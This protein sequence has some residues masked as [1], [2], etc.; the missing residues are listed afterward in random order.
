MNSK[1]PFLAIALGAVAVTAGCT[2]PSKGTVYD[3]YRVGRT[4]HLDTGDVVAVRDVT[5]SG[6][7]GPIG[8]S[9]GGLVGHAAGRQAAGIG[10]SGA[11]LAGA[12]GAVVGAIAG[13]AVEEVVTRRTA[14]EVTIKLKSGDTIAIVQEPKEG[15]FVVGEH[16]QVLQG[17]GGSSI[18]RL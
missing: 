1:L 7:Q 2:F 13:S 8:I 18:R 5:I 6:Q 16:V 4:M 17:A 12:G 3:R 9:G 10:A 14:Q 15:P 11:G